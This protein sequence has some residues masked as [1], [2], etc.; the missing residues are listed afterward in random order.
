MIQEL[1]DLATGKVY[2]RTL[3]GGEWETPR[4]VGETVPIADGGTGATSA[5][6]AV[7]SIAPAVSA[8]QSKVF[9]TMTVTATRRGN[10][11]TLRVYQDSGASASIVTTS[12]WTTIAQLK[13]GCYPTDDVVVLCGM[14][15]ANGA[16]LQL[17]VTTA[18]VVRIRHVYV[19]GNL[20]WSLLTATVSF[21]CKAA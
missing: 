7:K 18:G 2:R 8:L 12:S 6:G 4:R 11:V 21:A 1:L 14:Q 5:D 19:G 15:S 17:G 16:W 10:V 13:P 9:P 20:N 3:P